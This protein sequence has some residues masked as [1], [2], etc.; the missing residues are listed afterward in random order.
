MT[1]HY[2][3]FVPCRQCGTDLPFKEV[4][5]YEPGQPVAHPEAV[6]IKCSNCGLEAVYPGTEIQLGVMDVSQKGLGFNGQMG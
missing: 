5:N 2:V 3:L 6:E 1:D 4:A